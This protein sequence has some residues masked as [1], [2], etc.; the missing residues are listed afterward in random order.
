MSITLSLLTLSCG[1]VGLLALVGLLYGLL[2][3]ASTRDVPDGNEE[4][5]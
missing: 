2:V 3:A 1:C 4:Y 5:L